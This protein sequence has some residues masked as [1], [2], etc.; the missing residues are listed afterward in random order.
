M[1]VLLATLHNAY[2]FV[3]QNTFMDRAWVLWKCLFSESKIQNS[4]STDEK[5]TIF[6]L[7]MFIA[8]I[9][10]YVGLLRLFWMVNPS[11]GG[12]PQK[13]SKSQFP[14]YSG[15]HHEHLLESAPSGL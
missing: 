9:S 12:F 10:G 3:L 11:W 4:G 2:F 1:Q 6:L 15:T 5:F 14:T 8:A 13:T 7:F